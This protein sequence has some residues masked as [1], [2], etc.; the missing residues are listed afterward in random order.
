[1]SPVNPEQIDSKMDELMSILQHSP[2]DI[3]EVR[4][5]QGQIRKEIVLKNLQDHDGMKMLRAAI[6]DRIRVLLLRILN[7]KQFFDAPSLWLRQS[8]RTWWTVDSL[9]SLLEVMGEPDGA[10]EAYDKLIDEQLEHLKKQGF[11]GTP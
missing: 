2:E 11:R 1:M 3:D 5:W 6:H 4:Q 9:M 8:V 7:R 10:L